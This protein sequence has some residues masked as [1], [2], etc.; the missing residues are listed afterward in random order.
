VT[1]RL[2]A[3]TVCLAL[4]LCSTACI[5]QA[6]PPSETRADP[7]GR[8]INFGNA[9]EAPSEG[10][11]GLTLVEEY[12]EA[13]A[14][15]GFDT[16]RLPVKWSG[17]AAPAAPYTID[18]AFLARVDEVVGWILER[19]LNVIVDLH[20][21]DEMS[22][23]P[24]QQLLRW[25]GI[26]RQLAEHYRDAPPELAFELLNEPN[27]ALGG[28]LWND[29]IALGLEVIRETN[30]QRLVVVGPGSW[31]AIAALDELVVPDD[32]HLVLTVHYYEP[33]AFTHQGAEWVTPT[34]ATG[35]SWT[36]AAPGPAA[37]W[38]D[39]SWD[40]ARDYR[41]GL[42][43]TYRAGWA[44]FYLQADAPVSGYTELALRVSRDVD[45]LVL[46]NPEDQG[47]VPVT[48][49]SGGETVIALEDCG[50]DGTVPRLFLQNGTDSA[51]PPFTVQT[52]ELRGPAGTL[53]L[54]STELGAIHAAFD[55]V[56]EWA[57][58]HGDLPV[59]IGEFGAYGLADLASRVA[60]TTAVRRAAEDRGFGW[61]Y[62]E[63][64]AGFGAYD[65]T[66]MSWRPEL[67]AALTAD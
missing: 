32:E 35:V 15:A 11:W 2:V 52:L 20:H 18:P 50:S 17:H 64:G 61:A 44:G 67:L 29:M 7:F 31:N 63:F 13:I 53:P 43:I 37:G 40:T 23:A 66:A 22:V 38:Q 46:C 45:L 26:W 21:Y 60:W 14:A 19:D 49:R 4:L 56:D 3:G 54:L 51:Q 58:S 55:S 41:D 57:R 25:L 39:W 27:G 30:P 5:A 59:L 34:P 48:T 6:A 36:G 65:P 16:V 62:W 9:L 12:V 10:E 8:G 24:A 42:T 1:A 28:D 47:A 33:F